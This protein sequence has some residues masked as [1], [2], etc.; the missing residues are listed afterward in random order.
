MVLPALEPGSAAEAADTTVDAGAAAG[1]AAATGAAM[2]EQHRAG[3]AGSACPAGTAVRAAAAGTA[4]AACTAI[5]V[6]QPT[7]AAG[8]ADAAAAG[9]GASPT[10]STRP[11]AAEQEGV[12]A[13]AA[14]LSRRSRAAI[15]AVAEQPA[16]GPTGLPRSRR[17]I[18][19]VPE[20]RAPSQSF[21]RR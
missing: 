9:R 1:A 6:E 18:G 11:A 5:A 21:P 17:P 4:D 15:T 19:T 10:G 7:R 2:A 8:L 14:G 20:Q 13:F 12:T 3:A 16:A